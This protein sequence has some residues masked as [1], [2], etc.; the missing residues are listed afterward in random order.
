MSERSG[1][2]VRHDDNA[3]SRTEHPPVE[4]VIES[5]LE[6]SRSGA[7]EE[8]YPGPRETQLA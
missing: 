8:S 5:P 3:L 6:A 7:M 2:S 4:P 1:L